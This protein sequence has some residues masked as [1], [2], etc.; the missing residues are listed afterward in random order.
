MANEYNPIKISQL[1]AASALSDADIFPVTQA[2]VTKKATG[3]LIRSFANAESAVTITILNVSSA[4]TLALE[5]GTF[6]QAIIITGST[7]SV[8]VGTTLA[9]GEI[10]DDSIT[11]GTPLVYPASGVFFVGSQTLHFTGTFKVR[12]MSWQIGE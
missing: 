1:P 8:K 7:G 12:V 9:G 2:G 3:A 5:P 11:T 4:G 10:I 6:V